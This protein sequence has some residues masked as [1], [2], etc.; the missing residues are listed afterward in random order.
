MKIL[1]FVAIKPTSDGW[2]RGRGRRRFHSLREERRGVAGE[3]EALAGDEGEAVG[4][5][6]GQ[7]P[8]AGL[9][10][11]RH[12]RLL[13]LARSLAHSRSALAI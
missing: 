11:R 3:G 9:P 7:L 5:P 4:A 6:L 10:R 13:E 1:S 12:G 8:T 2:G